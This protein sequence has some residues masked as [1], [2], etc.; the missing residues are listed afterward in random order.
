MTLAGLLVSPWWTLCIHIQHSMLVLLV[1]VTNGFNSFVD[2]HP[3][4]CQLD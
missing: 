1:A 2:P 3:G 4:L